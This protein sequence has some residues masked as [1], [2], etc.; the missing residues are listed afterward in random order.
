MFKE[1]KM[2]KI[3]R[4]IISIIIPVIIIL[5]GFVL[6]GS[7]YSTYYRWDEAGPVI[8]FDPIYYLS[9]N[10]IGWIIVFIILGI[11]EYVWWK[12]KGTK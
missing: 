5:A 6:M 9:K 2:N 7:K 12:D 10:G 4:I 3:Q 11:F 1:L 8:V